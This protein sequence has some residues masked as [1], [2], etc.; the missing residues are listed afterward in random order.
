VSDDISKLY[1]NERK[2]KIKKLLIMCEQVLA[3]KAEVH[4][5]LS[6]LILIKLEI[7]LT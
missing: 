4:I 7:Q 2:N 1:N 6:H 3:F 5:K